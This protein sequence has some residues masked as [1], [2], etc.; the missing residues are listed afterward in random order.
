MTKSAG[1][2]RDLSFITAGQTILASLSIGS[3]FP[4]TPHTS[5]IIFTWTLFPLN[6]ENQHNLLSLQLIVVL[7]KGCGEDKKAFR[8]WVTPLF[9]PHKK[10]MQVSWLCYLSK[11]QN[12][13]LVEKNTNGC[14][15]FHCW[16]SLVV[17]SMTLSIGYS[18]LPG[19][20]PKQ[21]V[22]CPWRL[23]CQ[24]PIIT[25]EAPLGQRVYEGGTK[26]VLFTMVS[27]ER[28]DLCPDLH[29]SAKL[30]ALHVPSLCLVNRGE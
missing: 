21:L 14:K 3:L 5:W 4:Y 22:V 26:P 10:I 17:V 16:D 29:S 9:L 12:I 1:T 20:V 19:S 6:V 7:A 18:E 25:S 30:A 27:N 11:F 2:T 24:G 8:W 23:F 28:T 15:R 13:S